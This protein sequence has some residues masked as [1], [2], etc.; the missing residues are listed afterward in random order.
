[1]LSSRNHVCVYA[2]MYTGTCVF[3][4]QGYYSY[5]RNNKNLGKNATQY[6]LVL[7]LP[8]PAFL[9]LKL[10][11]SSICPPPRGESWASPGL[12]DN[13]AQSPVSHSRDKASCA[14][15]ELQEASSEA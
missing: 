14:Q 3:V 10:I 13:G 2:R 9:S 15:M 6:L 8:L 1:M 5:L 7:I 11:V 12:C 4:S